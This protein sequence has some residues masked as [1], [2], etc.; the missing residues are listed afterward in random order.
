MNKKLN[1]TS[2]RIPTKAYSQGV[3]VEN[4]NKLLF[5]TGQL[6]QDSDGNIIHVGNCEAQTKLVFERISK[7]LKEADMA[8]EDIVK[9]QIFVNDDTHIETVSA[10]RDGIFVDIRPAS[11]L[12]VVKGFVKDGACVEID[13]VASKI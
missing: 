9:L 7:I 12:V 4:T 5:V 6:P 3:L 8:F 11:T 2:L 1:P 13:A 10:V